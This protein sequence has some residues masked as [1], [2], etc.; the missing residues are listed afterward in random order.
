MLFSNF[1]LENERYLCQKGRAIAGWASKYPGTVLRIAGLL[2]ATEQQQETVISSKTVH[3]AIAIGRYF[4]AQAEFAYTQIAN[5]QAIEKGQ[6]LASTLLSISK[7]TVGHYE[8]FHACRGKFFK[9]AHDIDLTLELLQ[10]H[11]YIRLEQPKPTGKP[12]RKPGIQIVVNPLFR[13]PK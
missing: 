13:P 5:D 4:L 1:F 7:E 6:L 3:R 12:G 2:H 8:L 9:E 10:E 11:G